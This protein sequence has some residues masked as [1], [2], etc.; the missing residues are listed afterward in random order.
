MIVLLARVKMIYIQYILLSIGTVLLSILTLILSPILPL[1]ATEQK[2]KLDNGS[3]YGSGPRLPSWL[4]WFQTP[5][6]SLDGDVLWQ[7]THSKSY[8]NQVLWLWRNP[9]YAFACRY[10]NGTNATYSGDKDIKD[11]D[12]AK[13]GHCLVKAAGLFQYTYIKRIGNR[14]IYIN[15]GWNI[16]SLIDSNF[17]NDKWHPNDLTHYEAT[18]VFAPRISGFFV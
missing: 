18:F 5:D 1:F 14:C 16:K 6:N 3:V 12:G 15:L 13:E 8:R 11:N 7:I 2:G 4:N 10:I 17:I 9:A